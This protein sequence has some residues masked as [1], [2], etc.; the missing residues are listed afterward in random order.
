MESTDKPVEAKTRLDVDAKTG[1]AVD[2]SAPNSPQ[3]ASGGW[4][5]PVWLPVLVLAIG[6]GM[7]AAIPFVSGPALVGLTV[8]IG[9]FSA[10]AGALGIQSAGPRK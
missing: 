6:G 1:L 9:V 2:A 7:S 5:P 3:R 10:V 8:A 4:V